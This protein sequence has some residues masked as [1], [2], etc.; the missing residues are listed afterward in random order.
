MR[1]I[2]LLLI[3]LSLQANIYKNLAKD[4]R[5]TYEQKLIIAKAYNIGKKYDLGYTLAAIAI[6]ESQA[7]KFLVNLGDPSCGV[8]HNLLS[9]V[10]NREGIE[11]SNINRNYLCTKLIKDFEFASG[12]ALEELLY[13][14]KYHKDWEKT[15]MSYN[16]GFNY[17]NGDEY[18]L[19]VR[20]EINKL[21]G[22]L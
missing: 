3:G 19:K 13:W 7:G 8:Y 20:E 15:V 18:L 9:S 11:L 14:K 1:S 6:I 10:A 4:E 12:Q 22:V 2:L 5:F 17:R 21:K 16:A